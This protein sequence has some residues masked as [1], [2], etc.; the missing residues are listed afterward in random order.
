MSYDPSAL[1][2]R[3]PTSSAWALAWTR[4]YLRDNAE[5]FEYRDEELL[6]ALDA[7][8][9]QVDGVAYFRPHFAAAHV[10]MT[11]PNRALS[12][13]LMS[14]MVTHRGPIA[15]SNALRSEGAWIDDLIQT[16][17]GER[18]GSRRRLVPGF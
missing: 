12:E 15:I 9:F 10:I 2:V 6:A 3:D 4:L 13:S 1:S 5:P 7:L 16:I 8:Y 17:T 14:A 18:P 11:D